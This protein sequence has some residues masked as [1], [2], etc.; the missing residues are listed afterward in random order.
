[1]ASEDNSRISFSIAP[2][3]AAPLATTDLPGAERLNVEL[4]ALLLARENEE[5]RNPHPTHIP[6]REVFESDF[7]LFRW[8]EPCV[9]TL[10]RFVLESVG[11]VVAELSGFTAQDMARLT[12]HNHTWFHVTRHGG[13]FVAHNHPNA[14]WSSVYCVRAGD[15]VAERRD[16]GVLR[17]LD[18]RPGSNMF[19]DPANAHLRMPFN[20][21]HYSMRLR[22]GQ[23]VI[24]PSYLTHE[25]ATFMGSDIRITIASNCWFVQQSAGSHTT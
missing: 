22:A 8:P 12:M 15:E 3:F 16:S 25:V 18:H 21:G 7:D 17:F 5:H 13:S 24:F 23:L 10:R 6:Q 19:I 2:L 20:F 1:M 9:Q 11:R 4:E 14:S